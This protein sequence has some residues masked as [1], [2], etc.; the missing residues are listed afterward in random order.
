MEEVSL[1]HGKGLGPGFSL[2]G[3]P[4]ALDRTLLEDPR[5]MFLYGFLHGFIELAYGNVV[6]SRS[7][8]HTHHK[9]LVFFPVRASGQGSLL[10]VGLRP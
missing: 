10:V 3:R 5:W 4:L 8:M 7:T 6:F 2:S 9:H 1:F